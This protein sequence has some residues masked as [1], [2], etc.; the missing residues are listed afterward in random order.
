M[1]KIK[2]VIYFIFGCGFTTSVIA[3]LSSPLDIIIP[4]II[5][6]VIY[7]YYRYDILNESYKKDMKFEQDNK[8]NS[9]DTC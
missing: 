9:G 5:F 8:I 2:P 6:G 4:L 3:P 1:K 7:I